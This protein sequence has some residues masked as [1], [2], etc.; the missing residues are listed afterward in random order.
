MEPCRP[1]GE[2]LKVITPSLQP[3]NIQTERP[4]LLHRH[5]LHVQTGAERFLTHGV[6]RGLNTVRNVFMKRSGLP[7]C[8]RTGLDSTA[9]RLRIVAETGKEWWYSMRRLLS[10]R[11][12]T[13]IAMAMVSGAVSAITLSGEDTAGALRVTIDLGRKSVGNDW[14]QMA[15]WIEDTAG[16]YVDTLY[17]TEAVGKEGLGNAYIGFLGFTVRAV[18]GSLPVWAHA[19]NVLYGKSYYPPKT[20]PLPDGMTGA[21]VKA[22]HFL[23]AFTLPNDLSSRLKDGKVVCRM[24][25]NVARDHVPSMVFEARIDAEDEGLGQFRLVG[26]G[27]ENGSNGNISQHPQ[28]DSTIGD[29]LRQADMRVV[30]TPQS[31][32]GK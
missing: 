3:G 9:S 15:I 18:P 23:K 31:L 25:L 30:S 21:T 8:A 22:G 19:R 28:F 27:D 6:Q 16:H 11:I 20:D 17:V 1:L 5:A 14:Y 12:A 26:Y 24:E 32:A 2:A 10:V 7:S 4:G 29:Y 13:W